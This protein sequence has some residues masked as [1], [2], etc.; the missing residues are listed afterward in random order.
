M[1]PDPG[2]R[3]DRTTGNHTSQPRTQD[4][5]DKRH[6]TSDSGALKP[7]NLNKPDRV[8][9]GITTLNPHPT[10]SDWMSLAAA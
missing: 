5:D 8:G 4:S 1:L 7:W 2:G 6:K 3:L 10:R 9:G